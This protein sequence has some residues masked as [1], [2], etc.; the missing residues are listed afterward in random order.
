MFVCHGEIDIT[1]EGLKNS[2]AKLMPK[3]SVLLT[4]RAP[5]GYIAIADNEVSTNQGFKSIV[6]NEEIGSLFVYYT[7]YFM[8]PYLKSLGTGST[9]TEISKEVVSD[10][11]VVL[12][13]TKKV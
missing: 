7:L 9:F 12:P 8:I 10:V 6:P 4:S 5:I 1:Q 3:G 13:K 11:K 2:S